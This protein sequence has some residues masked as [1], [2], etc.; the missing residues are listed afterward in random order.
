[1]GPEA[2]LAA[3]LGSNCAGTVTAGLDSR[4]RAWEPDRP[5]PAVV[6]T[7]G[8]PTE[9]P[10]SGTLRLLWS[11]AASAYRAGL[12]PDSERLR[13]VAVHRGDIPESVSWVLKQK[14]WAPYQ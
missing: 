6:A 9:G 10:L 13:A 1:M 3:S 12:P 14:S 2:H 8:C 5:G 7:R 4:G 11:N